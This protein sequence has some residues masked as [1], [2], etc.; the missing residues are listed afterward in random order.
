MPL[1]VA[2]A[3]P[4][5]RCPAPPRAAAA[6]CCIEVD[7]HNSLTVRAPDGAEALAFDWVAGPATTQA[8][9]FAVV[10]APA[11]EACL[12]G[13]NAA[14]VAVGGGGGARA[15]MF[16]DAAAATPTGALPA[17]A[18]L[19]PRLLAYLWQRMPEVQASMLAPD[20]GSLASSSS[21]LAALTQ[22]GGEPRLKWLVRCSMVAVER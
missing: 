17:G 8:E 7:S 11:V 21:S 6:G 16:G 19:A 14:L 1:A 22:A 3:R 9:L 5:C 2:D 13:F 10:G 12:G 15:T 18:G 20:G 4:L